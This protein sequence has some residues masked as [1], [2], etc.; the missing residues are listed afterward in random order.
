MKKRIPTVV[1]V[2]CRYVTTIQSIDVTLGPRRAMQDCSIECPIFR[3]IEITLYTQIIP[4]RRIF[5]KESESATFLSYLI[6]IKTTEIQ[7]YLK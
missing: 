3:A 5:D 4:A 7:S 1:D 6:Y 2:A